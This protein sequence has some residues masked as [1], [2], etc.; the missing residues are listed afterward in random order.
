MRFAFVDFA[1]WGTWI[2]LV[3]GLGVGWGVFMLSGFVASRRRPN[4]F[5]LDE[6]LPWEDL[7]ELLKAAEESGP[8][9]LPEGWDKF[10]PAEL[11]RVLQ[12]R[13]PEKAAEL[14]NRAVPTDPGPM[15][16]RHDRRRSQRR[17]STPTE[18][19]ITSPFH[20]RQL[21]GLVIN[22]STG[23]LGILTDVEFAPKTTFYVR[24]VDAPSTVPVV[25]LLVCHCRS[26]G[27]LWLIGCQYKKEIPWSAKV[28]F[29]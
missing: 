2:S 26:A 3:L 5:G 28:W 17:Y 14:R 24:A 15:P 27:K 7:F 21:T 25:D 20:E 8:D 18:V 16:G 23:G 6:D 22:R 10:N 1:H 4:L 19:R 9:T 11:L 29:G 13:L 12:A